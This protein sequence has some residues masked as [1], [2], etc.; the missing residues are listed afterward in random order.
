ML[1]PGSCTR[2]RFLFL[3]PIH[4]RPSGV[5]FE[6]VT[7]FPFEFC[8]GAPLLLLFTFVVTRFFMKRLS[9][10]TIFSLHFSYISSLCAVTCSLGCPRCS[11]ASAEAC[12]RIPT[13]SLPILICSCILSVITWLFTKEASDLAMMK[14]ACIDGIISDKN[15]STYAGRNKSPARWFP[16]VLTEP[17]TISFIAQRPISPHYG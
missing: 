10:S 17:C 8:S 14:W 11:A 16:M 6:W 3:L 15:S 5:C 9:R 12:K 13:R 2:W 4:R 1:L 7:R